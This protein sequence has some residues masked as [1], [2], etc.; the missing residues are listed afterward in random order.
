MIGICLEWET[1]NSCLD[2]GAIETDVAEHVWVQVSNAT[3]RDNTFKNDRSR[4]RDITLL[5]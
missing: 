3:A 4:S 1:D 5:D 2:L